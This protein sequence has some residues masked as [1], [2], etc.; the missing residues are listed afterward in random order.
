MINGIDVSSVT[1]FSGST[2]ANSIIANNGTGNIASGNYAFAEGNSNI[3]SGNYSHAEGND[4]AA[5]GDYSHAKGYRTLAN[6]DYSHAE[7]NYT[8][9]SG[10]YSHAEGKSVIARNYNENARGDSNFS[11][12]VVNFWGITINATPKEIFL[13]GNSEKFRT[14]ASFYRLGFTCEVIAANGADLKTWKIDGLASVNIGGVVIF[15]S[16]PIITNI[17]STGSLASANISLV[18]GTNYD[19]YP[20]V[21]GVV[22][23][24]IEW[25]FVFRYFSV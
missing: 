4:T 22:A 6:G 8:Q 25:N 24:N 3:A 17:F 15:Q 20:V 9:A 1:L 19:I 11:Y 2:G 23:T 7:G 10:D 12:G 14:P 18:A 16:A 13:D 21:T 5:T